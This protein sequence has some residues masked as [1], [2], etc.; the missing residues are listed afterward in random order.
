MCPTLTAIDLRVLGERAGQAAP[1]EA[2]SALVC[3]GWESLPG[4]FDA[5][6]LRCVGTLRDNSD[7]D[8]SLSEYHPHGTH[9]WSADAPIAVAWFPYNRCDVWVC[10][11]CAR[12]F[13]RYA[14]FGSY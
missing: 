14:E 10:T 1:C 12:P 9:G 6:W 11:S 4:G 7:E 8:P 5:D 2:C 3:R 13:L